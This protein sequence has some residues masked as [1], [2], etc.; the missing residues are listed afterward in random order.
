MPRLLQVR[1]GSVGG[2]AGYNANGRLQSWSGSP[3]RQYGQY[4]AYGVSRQ[5]SVTSLGSTL[6]SARGG[7]YSARSSLPGT[8]RTPYMAPVALP[9]GAYEE[10]LQTAR[11]VRSQSQHGG[12]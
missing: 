7:S 1:S 11:S 8:A 10:E 9:P 6:P 4:N 3:E 2:L 5:T 12:S